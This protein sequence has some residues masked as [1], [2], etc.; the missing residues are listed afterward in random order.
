MSG[1]SSTIVGAI[2]AVLIVGA[3]AT[4]G[5]YQFEVAPGLV[6]ATSSVPSVT[7]PSSAC[8]NVTIPSGAS[9][10]APGFSPDTVTVVIGVNNTVFWTNSDDSGTPHTVTP[11]SG[12]D[13]SWGSGTLNRGDTYTHTFTVSGT[14]GYYCTFH[15]SVMT[16]TVIVKT[17]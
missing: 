3:V 4:L 8:V 10:I 5:Y 11:K 12:P 13:N 7:C 9:T 2:V 15:P 14:Y 17:R 6:S 16:G 1:Q